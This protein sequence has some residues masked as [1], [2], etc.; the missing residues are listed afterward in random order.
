MKAS[1]KESDKEQHVAVTGAAANASCYKI[2]LQNALSNVTYS[3]SHRQAG[4]TMINIQSALRTAPIC[5]QMFHCG[6]IW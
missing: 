6:V 4:T 2:R 1:A 3:S 5:V